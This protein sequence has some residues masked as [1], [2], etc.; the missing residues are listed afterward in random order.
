MA[1]YFGTGLTAEEYAKRMIAAYGSTPSGSNFGDTSTGA[2]DI[3][4][5]DDFLLREPMKEEYGG[6][7]P[8]APEPNIDDLPGQYT[9]P[10]TP[11]GGYT[12][13]PEIPWADQPG[14]QMKWSAPGTWAGGS[15][16]APAT[17]G[18]APVGGTAKL[19]DQEKKD[20]EWKLAEQQRIWKEQQDALQKQWEDRFAKEGADWELKFGKTSAEEKARWAEQFAKQNE[21]W[22]IQAKE[23]QRISQETWDKQLEAMQKDWEAKFGKTNEA[24]KAKWEAQFAA[25][26]TEWERRYNI[27]KNKKTTT[28]VI[29]PSGPMPEAGTMPTFAA[30]T[31]DEGRIK[32]LTQQKSAA[33]LR[34]MRAQI[35]KAMGQG[36][37]NENVK[38][39]T[40]R[41][42]LAG[43]GQGIESVMGG[44]QTA[45]GSE[46]N[47]E[48]ATA[49][50]TAGK[51]WQTAYQSKM[52][53]WQNKVND[54][55]KQYGT[56]TTTS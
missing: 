15:G 27:E 33:G 14:H 50:D 56:E 26:N 20:Y 47:T 23:A 24:E 16:K 49:Y 42:A 7:T 10:P 54:Y 2:Q 37:R 4:G 44:A 12:K 30:P 40:L 6:L 52:Q 25:A 19:T 53:D 29:G 9:G 18:T 13:T 3:Y 31:R 21:Q 46:Y 45:A 11:G 39:M 36:Y 1:N 32:E 28:R 41:D 5:N 51:N 34:A 43:Y 38:R 55:F 35:Q 22:A 48:Y 17:G 8:P